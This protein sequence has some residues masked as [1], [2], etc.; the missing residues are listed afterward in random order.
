MNNGVIAAYF[1][2]R[3]NLYLKKSSGTKETLPESFLDFRTSHKQILS[4]AYPE[5]REKIMRA[6][7]GDSVI[8][9][10]IEPK[11]AEYNLNA[12]KGDVVRWY[13][14]TDAGLKQ[15]DERGLPDLRFAEDYKGEN[16]AD[17]I[18]AFANEI[19]RNLLREEYLVFSCPVCGKKDICRISANRVKCVNGCGS[20]D[21]D[22]ESLIVRKKFDS[23]DGAANKSNAIASLLSWVSEEK[24]VSVKETDES[25]DKLNSPFLFDGVLFRVNYTDSCSLSKELYRT[26][27]VEAVF[28]ETASGVAFADDYKKYVKS[29]KDYGVNETL[30]SSLKTT[31]A[32]INSMQYSL[33]PVEKA[34]Y[35]Y[36]KTYCVPTETALNYR[37]N[38]KVV[39]FRD[40]KQFAKEFVESDEATKRLLVS[41][42]GSVASIS[43]G[44]PFFVDT[45]DKNI[46]ADGS[47][48]SLSYVIFR[49]TGKFV[50]ITDEKIINFGDDLIAD[51][52][53]FDNLV[54]ERNAFIE[55]ICL[56]L[57]EFWNEIKGTFDDYADVI[58]DTRDG[59]YYDRLCY[60]RYAITGK[61]ELRY[62]SVVLSDSS[63]GFDA[64]KEIVCDAYLYNDEK[65]TRL[66]REL[67]EILNNDLIFDSFD[68]MTKIKEVSVVTTFANGKKRTLTFDELR[69]LVTSA[70]SETPTLECYLACLPVTTKS[71]KKIKFRYNERV[72]TLPD[73]AGKLFAGDKRQAEKVVRDFYENPDVK[74][75]MRFV[76]DAVLI[77]G[78]EAFEKKLN[79]SFDFFTEKYEKIREDF[80]ALRKRIADSVISGNS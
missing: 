16:D 22:D 75:V 78:C 42:Y 41:V 13:K 18:L 14:L 77:D 73:H 67:K 45:R 52:C 53:R 44:S 38:G 35:Y 21:I 37:I 36:M 10:V 23:P 71:V 55:E 48:I 7:P 5:L 27:A 17:E 51:A 49:E 28:K 69:N 34:F 1:D 24:Q 20:F 47:S 43:S 46:V 54:A 68:K 57:P 58:Y 39:S 60:Y 65:S 72:A 12:K 56:S 62:K 79:D 80:S 26:F 61:K 70:K 6:I 9:D 74:A 40:E 50:Y 2:A 31:E 15:V 66:Y 30:Y 4:D 29:L 11:I 59:M 33:L 76:L 25:N 63:V 8:D 32:R 19:K 3:A 64:I